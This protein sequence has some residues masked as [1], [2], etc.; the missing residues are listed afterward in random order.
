MKLFFRAV[1][2]FLPT[3][4]SLVAGLTV[5]GSGLIVRQSGGGKGNGTGTG[6]G[7][8]GGTS[9]GGGGNGNG[10]NDPQSSL[11]TSLALNVFAV[12]TS[13]FST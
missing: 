6:G 12:F 5:P 8:G 4:A 3:L 13:L 7:G 10:N 2:V 9:S 11:S 1:F